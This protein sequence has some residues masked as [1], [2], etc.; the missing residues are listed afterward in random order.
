MKKYLFLF[1]AS[2]A[3]WACTSDIDVPVIEGEEEPPASIPRQDIALNSDEKD[4]S[5]QTNTFVFDLLK[6]VYTNDAAHKNILLSPLSATL[7]F[8]MLNNGAVGTTQQ[9][10]QQTLGYGNVTPDV[11]NKYL[12]KIINAMQELDPR[13][14]FE[15]ANSIWILKDYPVLNAFKQIN[16]QYYQADIQNVDF[17]KQA[18][19]TMINN[20]VSEKTHQKI[21]TILEELPPALTRLIL[22]NALYFKGFWTEPFNKSLTVD[23][24]FLTSAGTEQS[25]PTMRKPSNPMPYT[26]LEN[27][28]AVELT[29]GN[30]AFSLVVVL[31]DE[32]TDISSVVEQMNI[33]WWAQVVT[34]LMIPPYDAESGSFVPYEVT[35]EIPRFKVEYEKTLNTDLMDMGMQTPFISGMADFSLINNVEKLWVGI[36]KQKTF[37]QM[38]EEGMEAAAVTMIGMFGSSYRKYTPVDFKVNRPFLYFIKEKSTGLVFFAGVMNKIN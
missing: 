34:G 28:A 5:E 15:S 23:A 36:V 19:L 21:P 25:V 4:F 14:K 26:K 32:N 20:W 10:I 31:P 13:G 9:E 12:H 30:R 17:S 7:A 1:V 3:F 8:S 11:I 29:F 16:Q 38:D 24:K 33:D 6:T 2:L 18:T 35:L 37:A 27:C 22:I